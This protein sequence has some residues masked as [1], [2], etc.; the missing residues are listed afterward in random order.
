M[1][2]KKIQLK[3]ES[4]FCPTKVRQKRKFVVKSTQPGEGWTIG[5]IG[6]IYR[7]LATGE[8]TDGRYTMFEA[9]IL[10]GS[11][12]PPHTHSREEEA[13]YMLEGEV[14]FQIGDERL[15]AKPGSFINMPVGCQ[16]AFKNETDQPAKMLISL[17]PAGLE[18][19]FFEV[20]E[21]IV[22]GQVPPKPTQKEIDKLLEAA[23]RYGIEIKVP[24]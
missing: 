12:P 11:G 19:Y 9:V 2:F 7:F 4:S 23:P 18:E 3:D 5:I 10:P 17:A 8:D 14:T 1:H 24:D 20:G 6:D 16:H 15:V 21:P 22:E 13:F